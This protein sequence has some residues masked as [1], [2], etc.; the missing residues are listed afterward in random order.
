MT[1]I[2]FS[3]TDFEVFKDLLLLV[4]KIYQHEHCPP[5]LKSYIRFEAG[6]F[7]KKGLDVKDFLEGHDE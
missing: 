2:Q 7:F 1:P 4:R 6:K 5:I 3:L